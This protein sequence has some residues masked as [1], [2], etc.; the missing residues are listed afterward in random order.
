MVNDTY[1]ID[2]TDRIT[3]LHQNICSLRNKT[4]ELE[5]WLDS[6]LAQVD[7]ICLTEHWLN[8]QNLSI[9]NIHNFK[10]VPITEHI[11]PMG[12]L[13]YM[14]EKRHQLKQ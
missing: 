2:R 9:T 10:L 12:V 11:E 13:A 14:Q 6:E 1:L 3:I 8:N 5:I 7:V 4:T